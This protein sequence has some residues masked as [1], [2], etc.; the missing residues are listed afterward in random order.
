MIAKT[1]C[2]FALAI[3]AAAPALAQNT[4]ITKPMRLDEGLWYALGNG[5]T[6][7]AIVRG[8]ITPVADGQV[9][10]NVLVRAE[11]NC[12]RASP[13]VTIENVTATGP[14]T[15]SQLDRILARRATV[16]TGAVGHRCAYIPEIHVGPDGE[17]TLATVTWLCETAQRR[18]GA[19]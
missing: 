3:V 18:A 7:A 19:R 8:T 17:V 10:P 4:P 16:T 5:C 1:L 2:A 11:V 12:P 15:H 14:L 13:T 9:D 6:Y